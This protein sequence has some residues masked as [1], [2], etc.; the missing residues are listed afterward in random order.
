MDKTDKTNRTNVAGT[1]LS[2]MFFVH[3]AKGIG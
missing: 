3:G 2:D 1:N